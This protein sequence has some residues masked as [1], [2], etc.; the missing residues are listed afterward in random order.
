MTDTSSLS[1][2]RHHIRMSAVLLFLRIAGLIFIYDTAFAFLV[3]A[4]V[5]V[6]I[7]DAY[8]TVTLGILWILLAIKFL[9]QMVLLV[10]IIS[11]WAATRYYLTNTHLITYHGLI[12]SDET[13]C[14]LAQ[15]KTLELHQ[16]LFGR[17]FNYG[18][19]FL[20]FTS[21]GFRTDVWV[22]GIGDPRAYEKIIREHMNT[23]SEK[24]QI[25]V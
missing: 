8:G 19:L 3:L 24:R 15:L 9:V 13:L 2:S 21:S 18:D 11:H 20:V 16:S 7:G 5:A 14:E 22:R 6:G 12:T 23:H 1:V 10:P 4:L 25:I 17:I